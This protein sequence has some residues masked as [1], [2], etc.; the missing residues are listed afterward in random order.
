MS[1]LDVKYSKLL[2]CID[3]IIPCMLTVLLTGIYAF[4]IWDKLNLTTINV[5]CLPL[6]FCE[7]APGFVESKNRKKVLLFLGATFICTVVWGL[8]IWTGHQTIETLRLSGLSGWSLVWTIFLLIAVFS[9]LSIL[10]RLFRWSQEQWES[11][12]KLRQERRLQSEDFWA[13]YNSAKHTQRLNIQQMQQMHQKQ[14]QENKQ[15]VQDAEQEIKQQ[16]RKGQLEYKAKKDKDGREHRLTNPNDS[17]MQFGFIFRGF[18]LLIIVGGFF[19]FPYVNSSQSICSNWIN[20]VQEF[21]IFL[22][23]DGEN[24]QQA[25]FYYILFY[26]AVVVIIT[27]LGYLVIHIVKYN[28]QQ[29]ANRS[30][31]FLEVYQFPIAILVVF[32]SFLFVL[33]DGKLDLNGISEGW[34]ILLLIILLVLVLFTA[35]EIVRIVVAQC[36]DANSLLRKLIFFIFIAILKFLFELLIGVITNFRIQIV[37]SSLFTLV[38]PEFEEREISFNKRL[39]NKLNQLFNDAISESE[40]DNSMSSAS[41]ILHRQ[42]IWRRHNK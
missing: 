17:S 22:G 29:K 6:F 35:V 16:T 41:K 38:F 10:I 24:R 32:G 42:Q 37:I 12:Q 40:A 23:N 7:L 14:L 11:V 1:E 8:N 30:F 2:K 4:G 15:K 13:K 25:L 31:N 28:P 19:L 36:A 9:A 3:Q 27:I 33:T 39:S 34:Q 5:L 18:L 21:T 26:I 20:A